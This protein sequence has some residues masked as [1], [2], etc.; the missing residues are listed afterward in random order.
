LITQH[1]NTGGYSTSFRFNAK[2]LDEETGNYY[3]GA[4]YYNPRWSV[5][6]GV[7]PL[8]HKGPNLTPYAFTHNNPIV[9][10]DH[11]G[12]WPTLPYLVN[13]FSSVM[14]EAATQTARNRFN[15]IMDLT[16]NARGITKPVRTAAFISLAIPGEGKRNMLKIADKGGLGLNNE[17]SGSSQY[18][19]NGN[20]GSA[21]FR[22]YRKNH[23][24]LYNVTTIDFQEGRN[25]NGVSGGGLGGFG[26]AI[27]LKNSNNDVAFMTV[28]NKQEFEKIRSSYYEDINKQFLE[29]LD[30]VPMAKD[31]YNNVLPS[32]K[33]VNEFYSS[34]IKWTPENL[35]KYEQLKNAYKSKLNEFNQRW[36]ER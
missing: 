23:F 25:G 34:T 31:Y 19:F 3:Y 16:S 21:Y 7:D 18:S 1:A 20:S 13:W 22:G 24:S 26:F 36:N 11:D 28:G 27:V 8:A 12:Q 14:N 6:L 10:V 35:K 9:L 33:S 32:Y 4:R 29:L 15:E 2:E 17:I 30:G 5:W